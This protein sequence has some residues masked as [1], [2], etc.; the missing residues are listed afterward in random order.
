MTFEGVV[1]VAADGSAASVG[2]GGACAAGTLSVEAARDVL[3]DEAR[4]KRDDV[5]LRRL[6]SQRDASKKAAHDGATPAALALQKSVLAQQDDYIKQRRAARETA[7][8]GRLDAEVR[9]YQ[10]HLLHVTN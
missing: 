10:T 4:K 6:L 3:I 1:V 9:T 7:R 5:S 8:Q 2:D